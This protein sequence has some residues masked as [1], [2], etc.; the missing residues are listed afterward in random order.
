MD[1]EERR[2]VLL[3]VRDQGRLQKGHAFIKSGA[4]EAW[5]PE[6]WFAAFEY[7]VGVGCAGR[8]AARLQDC[9]LHRRRMHAN[10]HD[11]P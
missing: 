5:T 2:S 11:P 10:P 9:A 4:P 7:L 1:S 3:A 8:A 6:Q